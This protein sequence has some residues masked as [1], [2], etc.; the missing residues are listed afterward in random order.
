MLLDPAGRIAIAQ[1]NFETGEIEYDLPG[2]GIEPGESAETAAAREFEE[3]TG[4]RVTIGEG[5]GAA[6][7]Y[8]TDQNGD[9]NKHAHVFAAQLLPEP[10]VKVEDDHELVWL[11]PHDALLKL[12]YEAQAVIVLRALR[13]G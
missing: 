9:W 8:C 1:I 12:R 2:G 4:L 5:L 6:W 13:S 11:E 3:E 10:G 7:Q